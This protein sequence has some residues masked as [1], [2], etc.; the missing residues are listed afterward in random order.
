MTSPVTDNSNLSQSI[1]L[2]INQFLMMFWAW[3]SHQVKIQLS[4]TKS[5]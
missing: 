4:T 1:Q 2:W 5:S 3:F